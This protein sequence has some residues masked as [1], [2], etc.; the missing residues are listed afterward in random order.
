MA[1][2]AHGDKQA[3]GAAFESFL[4]VIE[5]E[6]G[7]DRNMVA[8]AVNWALRQIGK[9]DRALNRQAIK[10]AERIQRQGSRSARWIAAD[11]LRELQSDAVQQRPR[12]VGRRARATG[13]P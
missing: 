6:A 2:L 3:D 9:R 12:H 8:K 11:A 13:R 7:D 4:P 10:T 1:A 5:R